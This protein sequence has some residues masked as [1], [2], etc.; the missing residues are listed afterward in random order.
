MHSTLVDAPLQV[1][2]DGTTDP[3]IIVPTEQMENVVEALRAQSI[4]FKIND[5][6]V[7]LDG[8]SAL[9]V[10]DLSHDADFQRVQEVLDGLVS[11]RRDRRGGPKPAE[12]AQKSLIVT[13]S[14]S[15]SSEVR[16]RLDSKLPD[17]WRRSPEIDERMRQMSDE[18]AGAY[19]FIKNFA[20]KLGDVAVWLTLRGA[21]QL[22]VSP[23][24]AL[25][26]RESMDVGQYN[27]VLDDFET[28]F[29]E[30]LMHGLR[31]HVFNYQASWEPTL[32]D[33]LSTG[34]MR[35]L[36]AFSAIA[37]KG[38]LQKKD[39]QLWQVFIARTHLENTVVEPGLLSEWLQDEGWPEE[40]RSRLIGDY[41]FGRS[42][43][44]IYEE[45]RDER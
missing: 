26:A 21:N 41:S 22:Y 31:R 7:I 34:S 33:V 45:E 32:E 40:Q 17:D 3:Y 9:S 38:R 1:S 37:N 24:I 5:D 4:P 25:K 44:S 36:K 27:H 39:K 42:L 10:V 13:F 35:R 18:R 19:C 30:P 8:R 6:A 20:P 23:I 28:T 12:V 29:I 15:D 16:S 2:T 11:Q 14:L 43:L